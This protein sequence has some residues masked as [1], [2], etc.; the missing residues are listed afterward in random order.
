MSAIFSPCGTFRYRL[1]REV[2]P[3]GIV[4]AYF[5]VNGSTAGT[6]EN[7]QTVRKWIGFTF[8]N[9][10]QRFIV[11][12]AFA[13]CSKDVRALVRAA[14]PIGPDNDAHLAKI[15]QDADQLVPCW[16]SRDKLPSPLHSRL[17]WLSRLLLDSGKPIKGFGLTKSGDPLHPQMLGYSTPLIDLSGLDLL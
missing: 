13:F 11:G 14:D 2:Q 7:D 1:E 5:G 16:G 9:G 3:G 17:D 8:R 6:V 10:G 4:Y 12:N 15:I